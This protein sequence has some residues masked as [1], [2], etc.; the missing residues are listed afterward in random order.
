MAYGKA[1]VGGGIEEDGE[2]KRGLCIVHITN[3]EMKY[4]RNGRALIEIFA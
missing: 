2:R 1:W 3:H 4:C